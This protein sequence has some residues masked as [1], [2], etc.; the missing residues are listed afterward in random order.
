MGA[1]LSD[2]IFGE[3]PADV[4]RVTH[5]AKQVELERELALRRAVYPKQIE[6]GRLDAN[7]AA[8]QTTVLQAILEDYNIRPWPATLG[9]VKEWRPKAETLTAL[10]IRVSKMHRDELL[11]LLAFA[12]D[13]LRKGGLVE[14]KAPP[15]ATNRASSA[16]N[17]PKSETT[18]LGG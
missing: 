13:A 14:T 18:P 12:A 4:A 10:G 15:D 17:G 5:K 2:V 7:R 6:A 8:S 11:A 16:T 3:V 1:A 9:L